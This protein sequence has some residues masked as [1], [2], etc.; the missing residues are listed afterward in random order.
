LISAWSIRGQYLPRSYCFVFFWV[1]L[2]GSLGCHSEAEYPEEV[3][4]E[5]CRHLV[6]CSLQVVF[7][8]PV[9][10]TGKR[11]KLDW[12]GLQSGSL[13]GYL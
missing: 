10:R 1:F 12:T 7:K 13:G 11:P 8:G 4:Q 6:A 9:H 5:R 2:E 3:G